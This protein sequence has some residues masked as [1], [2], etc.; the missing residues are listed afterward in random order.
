MTQTVDKQSNTKKHQSTE[1]LKYVII[2]K[3]SKASKQ[4]PAGYLEIF[5]HLSKRMPFTQYV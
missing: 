5:P 4:I 2:D 1:P 3:L